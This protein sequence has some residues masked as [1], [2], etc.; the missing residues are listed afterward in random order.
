MNFSDAELDAW[1]LEATISSD[2]SRRVELYG[3]VQERI[4][5]EALIIPIREYVNLIG[6]PPEVVGLHYDAYGWFP[7]LTDLKIIA[8]T[9]E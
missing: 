9:N 5:E 2:N 3:L 1:L 4:M 8:D 7:F 6:A